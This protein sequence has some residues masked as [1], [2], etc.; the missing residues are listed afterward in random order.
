MEFVATVKA[1]EDRRKSKK[2]DFDGK[3]IRKRLYR[4]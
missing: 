3:R 2:A 1:E 4:G